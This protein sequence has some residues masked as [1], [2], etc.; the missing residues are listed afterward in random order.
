MATTKTILKNVDKLLV[1]SL[2]GD[3]GS[4]TVELTDGTLNAVTPDGY[5]IKRV[6]VTQDD[7]GVVAVTRNSIDILY[8]CGNTDVNFGDF[9][10]KMEPLDTFPVVLTQTGGKFSV[11]IKLEKVF[12]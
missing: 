1:V 2:V 5:Y 8:L 3:T 9:G 10:I 4:G 11:V 12:A 7:T 6:W